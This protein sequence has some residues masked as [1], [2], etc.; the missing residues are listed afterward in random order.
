MS[1]F[2]DLIY[3]CLTSRASHSHVAPGIITWD[4]RRNTCHFQEEGTERKEKEQ[5]T[6]SKAGG[7]RGA[8]GSRG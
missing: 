5:V 6:I 4:Y 2:I 8:C 7:H 3:K 1:Y